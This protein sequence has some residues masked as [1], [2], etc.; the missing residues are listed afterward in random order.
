MIK[1]A[2]SKVSLDALEKVA[3][4]SRERM[5][6]TL[7]EEKVLKVVELLGCVYVYGGSPGI[8]L[9]AGVSRQD[10][11]AIQKAALEELELRKSQPPPAET[12][13]AKPAKAEPK[14]AKT[15][16]PK[17]SSKSAAKPAAKTTKKK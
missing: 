14:P 5:D 7:T 2:L 13:A 17:T 9:V 3:S 11:I 4:P 16:K 12:T 1:T 8:S 15:A 10:V 6:E